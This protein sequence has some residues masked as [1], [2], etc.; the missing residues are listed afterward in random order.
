VGYLDVVTAQSF[1]LSN[2][3]AQVDIARRQTDAGVLLIK[4]LGGSWQ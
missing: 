4:A 1:A 3:R 2:E